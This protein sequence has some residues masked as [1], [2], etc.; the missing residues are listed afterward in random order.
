MLIV[1][2]G[3]NKNDYQIIE[4]YFYA[5]GGRMEALEENDIFENEEEHKA[6][7]KFVRKMDK[8]FGSRHVNYFNKKRRYV[9]ELTEAQYDALFSCAVR[10]QIDIENDAEFGCSDSRKISNLMNNKVFPILNKSKRD[11]M[12]SV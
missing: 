4:N 8:Y 3:Y 11:G 10:G 2:F 1:I 9:I 12:K 7:E 6:F 5:V